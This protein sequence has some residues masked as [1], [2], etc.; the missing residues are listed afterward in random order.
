MSDR[1]EINGKTNGAPDTEHAGNPQDQTRLLMYR[2]MR[3]IL[4]RMNRL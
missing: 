1:E 2:S 4:P 3:K